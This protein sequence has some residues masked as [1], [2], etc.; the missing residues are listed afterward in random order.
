MDAL[1][2]WRLCDAVSV[3]QAALLIVGEDP[4][5]IQYDVDGRP[6][7]RRPTGYDAAKAALINAIRG[8]RLPAT[9]IDAVNEDGTSG[10]CWFPQR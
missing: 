9:R 4:S 1:D 8:E 6:P 10:T 7:A 3:V 2:Y 5:V